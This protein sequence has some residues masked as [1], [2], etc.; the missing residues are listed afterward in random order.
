M[1][2]TWLLP[3]QSFLRILQLFSN[4]CTFQTEEKMVDDTN[5]SDTRIGQSISRK[6]KR[7]LSTTKVPF[8][9]AKFV[10]TRMSL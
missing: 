3:L 1:T 9:I 6:H 4:F 10:S 5:T 2:L 8:G 7:L